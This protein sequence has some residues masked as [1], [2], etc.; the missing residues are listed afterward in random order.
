MGED[1]RLH[2][3][4]LWRRPVRQFQLHRDVDDSGVSGTGVVAEGVVFWNGKCAVTWISDKTSVAVYDNIGKVEDIHGHGGHT[5]V[6][7]LDEQDDQLVEDLADYAHEAWSGWMEYLFSKTTTADVPGLVIPRAEADRWMRQMRTRYEALSEKEKES[8][9]I[10]ARKMIEIMD[11]F[12][13][14]EGYGAE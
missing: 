10:E 7:F 4:E 6:V 1:P 9:R 14:G 5:R 13:K 8:D 3:R 11:E 2:S 12:L